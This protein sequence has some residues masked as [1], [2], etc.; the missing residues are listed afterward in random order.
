MSVLYLAILVPIVITAIFYA[1]KRH[2]FTWWEFFIPI[3]SVLVTIVISKLLIDYKSVHFTE[4]WGSTITAV[5][6]EEPWNEWH[7]ETCYTYTTDSKGNTTS[8]AYD[9]SH[10]DDTGPSWY[11]T[12]NINEKFSITEKLHDELV[13]QFKTRKTAI[14]SRHNHSAS[15]RAVGSDGT[16]FEGRRVGETSYIYQT[17]WS[18]D[19]ATRKPYASEHSYVNKIKASDLTIFNMSV[20]SK[21]KA[22]SLGLFEYP[23]YE[24]GGFFSMTKGFEFPT[25]LGGKVSEETQEKFRKLNGKFGVSNELRLWILVFENKPAMI[26]QYQENYWVRG[27]MNE[28]VICIG[29]K[30]EEIQWSYA[31]SWS[32]SAQLTAAVKDEVF[33]LFN[34]KD[35]LIKGVAPKAIP[36]PKDIQKK[37]MGNAG[38]K[39][40]QGITPLPKIAVKDTVI[41][42]K[43]PTYPVL[44][45]KTWDAYY[46]YL[47]KNLG[48]YKRRSFKEFDYLSVEPSNTAIIIVFVLAF[49]I[50]ICVNIWVIT[51]DINDDN[52]NWR[53]NW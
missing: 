10:Q 30:G 41:K 1:F 25:I 33:N 3:G 15:S 37:I 27:N 45:E 43:S 53:R 42:V 19:D 6:E 46:Q 13:R 35:S 22:D 9:C 7:S 40:P 11:A 49:I 18:G 34:Y 4:Y 2:E 29:K 26:A 20:I 31:F 21:A 16:K 17:T 24:G 50:S 38:N 52:N 23:K 32:T 5:Y 44:N 28:L 51:N 47:N 48:Q 14:D 36:L 12:T 8:H 39:L